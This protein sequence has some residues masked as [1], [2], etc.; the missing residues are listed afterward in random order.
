MPPGGRSAGP[1]GRRG[2]GPQQAPVAAWSCIA[3]A[4]RVRVHRSGSAAAMRARCRAAP[5]LL[6]VE[7]PSLD[8]GREPAP[9]AQA[10]CPPRPHARHKRIIAHCC[11][12][13][14]LTHVSAATNSNLSVL[15]PRPPVARS[16]P[17]GSRPLAV[18]QMWSSLP[19][20]AVR[21]RRGAACSAGAQRL[22]VTGRALHGLARQP[23]ILPGQPG[24]RPLPVL[25]P[26]PGSL[27]RQQARQRLDVRVQAAAV[28]STALYTSVAPGER[29]LAGATARACIG[30][31]CGAA[32][33]LQCATTDGGSAA[34]VRGRR[35]PV[36]ERTRARLQAAPSPWAPARPTPASTSRC[37]PRPPNP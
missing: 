32:R 31:T 20:D 7:V 8:V 1:G 5:S 16:P 10:N 18:A 9:K 23:R 29:C 17:R 4:E 12:A 35:D 27:V 15:L 22:A 14:H 34:W 11:T 3:P 26:V 13:S 30:V 36:H 37:T 6:E 2:K 21:G 19:R 28:Q 33:K 25:S 24:C